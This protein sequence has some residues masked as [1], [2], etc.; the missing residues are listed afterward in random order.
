[1]R[2]RYKVKNKEQLISLINEFPKAFSGW[3]ENTI[4]AV[5]YNDESQY[6]SGYGKKMF[7]SSEK[8]KEIITCFS[9]FKNI[10]RKSKYV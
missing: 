4:D 1:M 5:F 6:I 2:Y 10:L 9:R 3:N 8:D 7:Y